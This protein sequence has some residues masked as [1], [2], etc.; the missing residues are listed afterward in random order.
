MTV[1]PRRQQLPVAETEEDRVDNGRLIRRGGVCLLLE[2]GRGTSRKVAGISAGLSDCRPEAS[3][4]ADWVIGL[5][6]QSLRA[7]EL[8]AEHCFFVL[9]NTRN[10]IS[11][12]TFPYLRA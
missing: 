8:N 5:I 9:P 1:R 4:T 11:T 3:P 7:A 10:L 6:I 2:S 12:T